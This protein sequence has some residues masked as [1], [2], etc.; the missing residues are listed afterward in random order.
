MKEDKETE[1]LMGLVAA[2]VLTKISMV[3]QQE[4]FPEGDEPH[5]VSDSP[6]GISPIGKRIFSFLDYFLLSQNIKKVLR[7]MGILST[8][9]T[10]HHQS[11]K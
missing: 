8:E 7:A 6:D 11:D 10:A 2:T 4:E 5:A 3:Q 1:L 9:T